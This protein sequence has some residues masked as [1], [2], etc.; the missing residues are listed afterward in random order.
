MQRQK[1]NSCIV[2]VS[3]EI[4][5]LSPNLIERMSTVGAADLILILA[6]VTGL[7]VAGL[8]L[9]AY[10]RETRELRR[11][12]REHLGTPPATRDHL[13]RLLRLLHD[14]VSYEGLDKNMWRPLLRQTAVETLNSG[15]GFC[16][17]NARLA[18][19]LMATLG[20]PAARVY[21]F[22]ERWNHV[23]TECRLDGR[24][25]LFDGHNDPQTSM[26]SAG[27][28]SIESPRIDLLRNDHP[29]PYRTFQRIPLFHRLPWLGRFETARL[30]NWVVQ[31][32]ESP[33]LIKAGLAVSGI[34]V[35]L[36]LRSL[37]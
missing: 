27:V 10:F 25:W 36:V 37:F 24:W 28:C 29:N 26:S 19:R 30:P 11:V 32:F 21:V 35:A 13:V 12:A 14:R 22:G 3:D 6:V 2:R 18:I 4:S 16:G 1:G 23:L 17:E 15:R 20:V 9:W 8:N 33:N 31:L 5:P 7:I 34:I